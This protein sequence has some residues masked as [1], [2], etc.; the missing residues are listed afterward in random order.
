MK[1]FFIAAFL[2]L[3]CFAAFPQQKNR[4]G[5]DACLG[6]PLGFAKLRD[7][8]GFG[9]ESD[10]RLFEAGA[11][12]SLKT[13]DFFFLDG[14][15]GVYAGFGFGAG[16]LKVGYGGQLT[17]IYFETAWD[18]C[19]GPAFGIDI[20]K[21]RLQTGLG[22]YAR[23]AK[24]RNSIQY[25]GNYAGREV[26]VSHS[27]TIK[28]N[29]FGFALTP[30]ARLSPNSR[31]SFVAGADISFTFPRKLNIEYK[32]DF[33]FLYDD[34]YAENLAYK[35]GG[36]MRFGITPYIALGINFGK[37]KKANVEK[38]EEEKEEIAEEIEEAEI[39]DD[40]EVVES[41]TE[42]NLPVWMPPLNFNVRR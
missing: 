14:M 38:V 33:T 32:S 2:F 8:A 16:A 4:F 22:F 24:G 27:E 25:N 29:A 39:E 34:H 40:D 41:E 1:N 28:Y 35:Y 19:V 26:D 42:E 9:G 5:I 30:Q 21:M 7:G 10:A 13:Y 12:V 6:V 3:A 18:F 36:G 11:Q 23:F 15:L 31:L 17:D 37:I 20:G